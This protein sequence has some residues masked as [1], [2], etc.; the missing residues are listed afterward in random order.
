MREVLV[1][2]LLVQPTWIH[3]DTHFRLVDV[4]QRLEALNIGSS[5]EN[6]LS[7]SKI[8]VTHEHHLASGIGNSDTANGEVELL[9]LCQHIAGQGGP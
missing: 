4:G 9:R 5:A 7:V 8:A 2:K 3:H 1:G 6:G